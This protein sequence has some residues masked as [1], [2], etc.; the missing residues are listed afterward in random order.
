MP[1]RQITSP[2]LGDAR[3]AL[4]DWFTQ[5]WVR[6]TGRRVD[7]AEA[8]WIDGPCGTT[9]RIGA[10][11]F[12]RH[13]SAEG[14]DLAQP[15]GA[16]LMPDFTALDG[17]G[18]DTA[19]LRPEIRDFYEHTAAYRLDV[20]SEWRSLFRPFGWALAL[21]FSRRLEQLNI[22]LSSLDTARG[23]TN[24]IL[25]L[26]SSDPDRPHITGWVRR[27]RVSDSVVYVG[28]YSVATIPGH[29]GPCVRVV[30]PLPNGNATVILEPSADR[31]GALILTSSGRRF[32]D[33]G[34][35]F[36]ARDP[37]GRTWARTVRTFKERIRVFVDDDGVLRTDHDFRIWGI[38][39]LRLHYRL[40]RTSDPA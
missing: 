3:G 10:D 35:Y 17:P 30:F 33:A 32:G 4:V 20:W 18:F 15:E 9:D 21:I 27:N 31:T 2:W 19:D 36:L 40:E 39:F 37:E 13:A 11:F 1:D 25:H 7:L 29:P 34:F 5:R 24:T 38:R 16:G 12:E 14:L 22:P 28:A 26:T 6:L 8:R 23:M